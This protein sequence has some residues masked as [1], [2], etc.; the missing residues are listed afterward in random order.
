MAKQTARGKAQDKRKTAKVTLKPTKKNAEIWRKHKNRMDIEGV[1]T[2]Q[3]SK[4]TSP[5]KS[6]NKTKHAVG[7]GSAVKISKKT[8]AIQ[9]GGGNSKTEKALNLIRADYAKHG[10]DTGTAMRAYVEN[11]ISYAK[12][13]EYAKQG[14]KIFN[15]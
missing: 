5:K 13:Q 1:D 3:K 15:K 11:R 10:K 14:M 12:Y 6:T 8:H 4:A 9:T 2:K 7:G